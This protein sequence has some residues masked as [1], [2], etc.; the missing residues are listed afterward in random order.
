[1]NLNP[2]AGH[3]QSGRRPVLVLSPATYNERTGLAIVCPLTTKIKG[4]AFEVATEVG[5]RR[6]VVLADLVKSVDWTAR[7]A[8]FGEILAAE[9]VTR[10]ATLVS[11]LISARA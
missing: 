9:T 6:G 3:E 10:V 8:E 5:G 4:Y 7:R 2:Q 11:A 1:M